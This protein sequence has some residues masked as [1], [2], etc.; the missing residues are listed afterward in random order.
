MTASEMEKII[1]AIAQLLVLSNQY[2]MSHKMK[3]GMKKIAGNK[4]KVNSIHEQINT[5]K[6][7]FVVIEDKIDKISDRFDS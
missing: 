3:E 6:S 2:F 1:L 5:I 7:Y 4:D